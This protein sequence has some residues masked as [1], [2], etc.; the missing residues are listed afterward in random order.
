MKNDDFEECSFTLFHLKTKMQ[1]HMGHSYIYSK[2]KIHPVLLT[3]KFLLNHYRGFAALLLGS[4]RDSFKKLSD[5]YSTFSISV[6]R[7]K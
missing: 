5:R 1:N 2:M 6:V 3:L 7:S 4:H